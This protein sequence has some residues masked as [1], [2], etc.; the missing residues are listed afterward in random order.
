M[1]PLR[2]TEPRKWSGA[3]LLL[4]A[5]VMRWVFANT[6]CIGVAASSSA[7]T[8]AYVREIEQWRAARLERLVAPDGWLSLVG[9]HLL[10]DG[11]NTIGSANDNDVV[12]AKLPARFGTV[13]VAPDRTVEL[14]VEPGVEDVRVNGTVTSAAELHLGAGAVTPTLVTVGSMSFFVIDRG[15]K[16]ALRVKDSDADRR[17]HFAGIDYFP[18]DPTWRIEARWV[19]FERSRQIMTT[20]SEGRPSPALVPG[21]AVFERDGKQIEL[22]AIDEGLTEPLLFVIS[23]L[24]TGGETYAAARFLSVERPKDGATIVLD[25]NRAE[26]PPCAFTPFAICPLP[27]K[28]NRLPFAVKVGEKSYR[29]ARE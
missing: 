7:A 6:A 8:D 3:I 14:R 10:K 12:I 18:I 24:T 22:L 25:F 2:T 9:L 13:R 20:N 4:V 1:T 21:K 27:P 16:K 26:N 15:G 29:G 19:A 11:V 23:D 5:A 17:K 28:E